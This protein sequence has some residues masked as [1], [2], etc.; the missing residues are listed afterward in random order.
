MRFYW[1]HL[2]LLPCLFKVQT[3][4]QTQENKIFL[5]FDD[6]PHPEIT[7]WVLDTLEKYQAKATFF[8]LGKNVEKYPETYQRLIDQGHRV[9]NHGYAHLNGW[10]TSLKLYL[11]DVERGGQII[12]SPLFRPAYGKITFRQYLA[13]KKKH[14]IVLWDVLSRDYDSSQA[15][16][17]I[18]DKVIKSTQKGSILVFHDSEKAFNNLQNTLPGL[19]EQLK[20]K[21]YTFGCL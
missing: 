6:G 19:L 7:P 3:H 11:Q 4:V 15:P 5:T 18:T 10:K 9:G 13:L 16:S 17:Q 21:R 2:R 14:T 8:C 1:N 12:S 20:S